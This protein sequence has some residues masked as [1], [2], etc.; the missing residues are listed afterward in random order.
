MR[1]S[2]AFVLISSFVNLTL[3]SMDISFENCYFKLL[4]SQIDCE[5]YEGK[6]MLMR[7]VSHNNEGKGVYPAGKQKE[8]INFLLQK[9]KRSINEWDRNGK[10]ALWYASETGNSEGVQLLV[11][12]KAT[13]HEM[14]F[15]TTAALNGWLK[16]KQMKSIREKQIDITYLAI[17][18]YLLD[19]RFSFDE[20]HAFTCSLQ[21]KKKLPGLYDILLVHLRNFNEIYCKLSFQHRIEL[22]NTFKATLS[23]N[24]LYF[25][26]LVPDIQ[27]MI[28]CHYFG[29][30]T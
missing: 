25:S 15:A 18:T 1:S 7:V 5:K 28:L 29:Q 3:S 16:R 10:T 9:K 2:I 24:A 17:I 14:C 11:E 27:K 30:E 20:L 23:N 4:P 26:L 12:N 13:D 21:Y 19:K 6:T 22:K 8:F